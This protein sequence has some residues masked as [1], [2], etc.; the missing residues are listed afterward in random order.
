M[1]SDAPQ[2]AHFLGP[3]IE[4]DRSA[5][6][7]TL[8]ATFDPDHLAEAAHLCDLPPALWA[9][10]PARRAA[11]LAGRLLAGCAMERLG[12]APA[13]LPRG[14]AGEPIWPAPLAG[15]ISHTAREVAVVL[16][17]GAD[18]L[19]LDLEHI[20]RIGVERAIRSV[21]LDADENAMC[22][23]TFAATAVFSAKE[24]LYKALFPIVRRKFGFSAARLVDPPDPD[25]VRLRLVQDLAPG[26]PAGLVIPVSLTRLDGLILTRCRIARNA[27]G[28]LPPNSDQVA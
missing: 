27:A 20:A 21:V 22:G 26:A 11:F 12:L 7:I 10:L 13:P 28:P 4:V 1:S 24:A 15:S 19:G 8:R 25:A 16:G 17:L 18:H 14:P 5:T 3:V 23:D 6:E 9:A 2:G